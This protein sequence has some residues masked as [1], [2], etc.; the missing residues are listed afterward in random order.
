MS[1]NRDQDSARPWERWA[2]PP[3]LAALAVAVQGY[4]FGTSDQTIHLTLLRRLVEPG[5]LGGD[6]V[7]THADAHASLFWHVQVPLVRVLGWD[8]VDELYL[9]AYLGCLVATFALLQRLGETL[10]QRRWAWVLGPLL[11]VVSRACPG[12]VHTFEPSLINRTFCHPLVLWALL[13][14]LR[15]RVVPAAAVCGLA[16]DLHASTAAHTLAAVL[17]VGVLDAGQ[18]RRLPMA[19]L[20]FA[21][22]AAPL[23]VMVAFRGGPGD[24]WVDPEWMHVLRWRMPHHLFPGRWPAGVWAVAAFQLGLYLVGSR[25]IPDRITRIRCHGVVLGVL[26]CGPLLGTVV[27]GPLPVAPLLGLH[28]WE[29]WIVLAVLAYLAA[30]GL[31][32]NLL[33]G[34]SV[35]RRA[36]G[37]VV[38]VLLLLGGE[39]R[40][41]GRSEERVW[42]WRA[43]EGDAAQL[44]RTLREVIGPGE[45]LM[46]PPTGMGWVR[47]AG[48]L[49]LLVTV[50]DG[51]EVV[52]DRAMALQ[53]RAA[54]ADLCGEDVIA[55]EPPDDEWLGYRSVGR[56]AAAA[57]AAQDP[58]AL[59]QLALRERAWL[60]P[61]PVKD[62]RQDLTPAYVN[63][64]YLVYDLRLPLPEDPP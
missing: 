2:L 6:L 24:W 39:A 14:A 54:L 57:F 26:I 50:K 15:G 53:W 16:F 30:G 29:S 42:Q 7:A 55:G 63:D 40:L 62:A 10:F 35:A 56:R 28:L 33:E 32:A 36:C 48:G 11:L 58:R 45:R 5:T 20:G 60:I 46:A 61:V 44:V 31:L 52:F 27:A 13:L 18:R 25:W 3:A 47:P 34:P 21:L 51:G 9:L 23:L 43:P 41:M 59:Q 12:H 64:G 38:L 1:G 19:L 22:C 49:P 4:Q 37:A 8:R 17:A